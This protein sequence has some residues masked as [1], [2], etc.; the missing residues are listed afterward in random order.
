MTEIVFELPDEHTPGYLRRLKSI[1]EYQEAIKDVDLSEIER[2]NLMINFLVN[3]VKEPAD[4][5]QAYEALLDA[6]KEQ[7]DDVFKIIAGKGDATVPPVN[8]ES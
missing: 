2:L 4:K 7:I 1:L 3:Y 8:G 6:N 5:E